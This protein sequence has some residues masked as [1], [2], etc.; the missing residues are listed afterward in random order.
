MLK[1]NKQRNN[2]RCKQ[3]SVIIQPKVEGEF[4]LS[5]NLTNK[6][7]EERLMQTGY[8]I[9]TEIKCVLESCEA[10]SSTGKVHKLPVT[11]KIL[12]LITHKL[13]RWPQIF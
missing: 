5:N 2:S 10:L 3:I 6:L 9:F 1:P 7:I 11:Y 4:W 13:E 8:P 12:C